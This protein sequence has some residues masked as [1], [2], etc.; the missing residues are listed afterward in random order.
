M[1]LI[2]V[3]KYTKT[4]FLVD[5]PFLFLWKKFLELKF[6]ERTISGYSSLFGVFTKGLMWSLRMKSVS[7]PNFWRGYVFLPGSPQRTVGYLYILFLTPLSLPRGPPAT[8]V[9]FVVWSILRIGIPW[10][11]LSVTQAPDRTLSVITTLDTDFYTG[12]AWNS[13]WCWHFRESSKNNCSG[14]CKIVSSG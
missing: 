4:F 11:H 5:S 13:T 7:F 3:Y 12:H 8:R 9:L 10:T 1:F 6:S 2:E 14:V